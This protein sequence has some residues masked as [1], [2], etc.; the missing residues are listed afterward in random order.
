LEAAMIQL[1]LVYCMIENGSVCVEDR[2][3]YSEPMSMESCMSSAQFV[4]IDY[5][6]DHP[7]W[8][9]SR[10]SCERD[11]PRKIPT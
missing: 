5:V 7:R 6:R 10:W 3:T 11:V 4:A 8:Q 2:P 9:L 1:V